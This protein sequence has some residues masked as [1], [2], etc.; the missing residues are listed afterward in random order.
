MFHLPIPQNIEWLMYLL[1][2]HNIINFKVELAR[3]SNWTTLSIKT[4][5]GNILRDG[6]SVL[7]YDL[8]TL[9]LRDDEEINKMLTNM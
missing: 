9:Q 6:D 5:L 1:L 4:H 7:G 2:K 3:V 8:S